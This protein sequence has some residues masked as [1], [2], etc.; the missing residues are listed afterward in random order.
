MT[1]NFLDPGYLR[2]GNERQR[3]AHGA[4]A[5][6]RI[7][8]TLAP[9]HPMLS[10]TIPLAIDI[11]GSDLDVLCEVHDF[12]R[13]AA[14]LED[15]YGHAPG[16]K[17][18]DFKEGRDGPYR[19]ASFGHGGFVVEVFGQALA[20]TRQ[21]AYRHMLIQARL[22]DLGGDA[23]RCEIVALREGGL[24]TEPAFARRLG[25]AGDPY[26]ALLALEDMDDD[27]LRRL[28]DNPPQTHRG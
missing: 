5:E 17:L 16:F 4:L 11:A 14:A 21:G 24:K 22:L 6:L 1:K 7:F 13:F 28:L 20:V 18:S 26:V 19:T 3:A 9:Y 27:D 2:H 8:E 25:I 10:G 23:L 15:A 12:V